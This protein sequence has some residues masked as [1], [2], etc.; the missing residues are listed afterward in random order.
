[1]RKI[2]GT[3]AVEMLYN[4]QELCEAVDS[5]FLALLCIRSYGEDMGGL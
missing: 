5:A 3:N 1:M 2:Q 4:F